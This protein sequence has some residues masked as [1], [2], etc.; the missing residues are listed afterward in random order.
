MAADRQLHSMDLEG[1]WMDIGQP[2]DYLTGTC[3]Y[4]S[5]L[6]SKKAPELSDPVTHSWVFG[7]NV[8]VDPTATVDPSAVIGPNV[9]IGPGVV[10][11]K[12]V[13]LQRC[14]IMEG[15]RV[16]DH[17]WI[18]SS[19]VGW[20]S[21]VGRWVRMENITVLGDD[22][23]IK[24]ELLINGGSI[25]PHKNIRYVLS[26]SRPLGRALFLF[27]DDKR[28]F[29]TV[30]VSMN[31]PSSCNRSR[32]FHEYIVVN[33][34]SPLFTYSRLPCLHSQT[35]PLLFLRPSVIISCFVSQTLSCSIYFCLTLFFFLF[36]FIW[37]RSRFP[38][39]CRLCLTSLV[40]F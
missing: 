10:I 15:A 28:V 34:F 13:R 40:L 3:L 38:S 27:A 11:G 19:I 32:P 12:G 22:V 21:T 29:N 31:R 14:V 37:S 8:L 25:L 6:T 33:P 36:L 30:R 16:K 5:Y 4:L 1:F 9:V 18:Q 35:L 7:G 2:K 20:N 17:A 39:R 24:D 26:L 23:N